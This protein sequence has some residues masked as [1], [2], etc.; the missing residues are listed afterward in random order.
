MGMEPIRLYCF[1]VAGTMV[2]HDYSDDVAVAYAYN[3]DDAIKKFSR[4]YSN[5]S[6]DNVCEI[7]FNDSGVAILTDY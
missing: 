7:C 3:L 2:D 4:Y 1:S 5:A 6:K